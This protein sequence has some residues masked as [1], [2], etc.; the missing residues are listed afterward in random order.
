MK[1]K[2]NLGCVSIGINRKTLDKLE[3]HYDLFTRC[4]VNDEVILD[5]GPFGEDE[6]DELSE[7]LGGDVSELSG[8][9]VIIYVEPS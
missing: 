6:M 5:C 1:V 9:Y 3:K 4:D 2:A 8:H 7:V